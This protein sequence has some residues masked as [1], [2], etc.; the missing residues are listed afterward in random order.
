MISNLQFI[1][2]VI[3]RATYHRLHLNDNRLIIMVWTEEIAINAHSSYPI[4]PE[5]N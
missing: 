4:M 2:N 3:T 5:I 1:S